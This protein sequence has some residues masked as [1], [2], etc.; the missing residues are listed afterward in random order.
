[1]TNPCTSSGRAV[2]SSNFSFI[3]EDFFSL[4]KQNPKQ[5]QQQSA[6]HE[7]AAHDEAEHV[8]LLR[9]VSGGTRVVSERIRVVQSDTHHEHSQSPADGREKT[10]F[11]E[12]QNTR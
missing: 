7:D 2:P 8:V 5:T 10:D 6:D 3:A 11:A 1:M 4:R 9:C 12:L